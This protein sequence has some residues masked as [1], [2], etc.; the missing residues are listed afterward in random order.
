MVNNL[1]VG[2]WYKLS[3]THNC[4]RRFQSMQ[5]SSNMKYD[6]LIEGGRFKN[7]SGNF[8]NIERVIEATQ[9]ELKTY[10]PQDHPDLLPLKY[11]LWK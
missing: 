6:M 11:E 10:L 8:Q 3:G 9:D 2:K 7:A 1:I 4:F 5:N